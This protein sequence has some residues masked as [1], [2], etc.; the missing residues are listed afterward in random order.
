GAHQVDHLVR[1]AGLLQLDL[2]ARLLLE[3]GLPRVCDVSGPGHEV[4]LP[5]ASPDGLLGTAVVAVATASTTP[6]DHQHH[7]GEPSDDRGGQPGGASSESAHFP[8]SSPFTATV[9]SA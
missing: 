6:G 1:G 5:L 2:T 3:I 9:C 4:Q 8:S 7:G